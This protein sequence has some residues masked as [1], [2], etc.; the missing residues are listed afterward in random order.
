MFGE[1]ILRFRWVWLFFLTA[2]LTGAVFLLPGLEIRL[3]ADDY[4]PDKDPD[5]A[6]YNYMTSELGDEDDFLLLAVHRKEGI[7]DSVFLARFQAFTLDAARLPHITAAR[8]LAN[9]N[10]LKRTPFGVLSTPLLHIS[11][12]TLY[13]SDS[14]KILADERLLERLVSLDLKTLNVILELD[15]Q[16]SGKEAESLISSIEQLKREYAFPEVHLMGRKYFE[17]SHNRTSFRELVKGFF[18]C[19]GLIIVLLGYLYRSLWAVLL[20]LLVYICA[21]LLF[22]G[23]LVLR[24]HPVDVMT[25]L[26]PTILLIVSVSDVIHFFSKYEDQVKT[27]MN[28]KKALITTLNRIGLMLFL[29][30]FSTAIG[31]L[32]F[33]NSSLPT[34]RNFGGDIAVG[35]VLTFLITITLVP[36]ALLFVSEKAIH[37][38][39]D[40]HKWWNH[41]AEQI[42]QL[43]VQRPKFIA[44][45]A[46]LLILF[47][48]LVIPRINTNHFFAK[49][50]PAD[51]P[52]IQ[53][54]QFFEDHLG[55]VRTFEIALKPKA[56]KRLND[57]NVLKEIEKLHQHVDSLPR[58]GGVYS[59][60]TYY[61][62]L[63]KAWH[64]SRQSA[65]ALP[66]TQRLLNRQE[67]AF[68]K[69]SGAIFHQILNEERTIGKISARMNDPGLDNI[70]TLNKQVADWISTKLDSSLLET[71]IIGASAMAD[72]IQEYSIRSMFTGLAL[73]LA[74]IGL[75]IFLLYREVRTTLTVLAINLFPLILTGAIMAMSGIVLRCA[76]SV[77]FSIGFVI[78][79]DDTIH[80]VGRFR[81]ERSGGLTPV[82]SAGITLRE[83]GRAILLTSFV[84]F[85]GFIQLITSSF[86]DAQAIGILVSVMLV[87]AL[88][89]DLFLGPLLLLWKREVRD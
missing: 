17:V 80:F 40:W 29:T 50:L 59:P 2:A 22:L 83:T 70:H 48:L 16:L 42:L 23:Y 58:T 18:L 61:K 3:D 62:S 52:S 65:Y 84:L 51:H 27:G 57:L 24:G 12:P 82:E 64:S 81:L 36:F 49:T 47:S 46:V 63:N 34:L 32:T 26:A 20:P 86:R 60:A 38:R 76:T 67:K 33:L 45:T 78:A 66:P 10:D 30:S 9:L 7:F 11:N 53:S 13:S 8:S 31:F 85:F 41:K 72:K 79:I 69:Q 88:L 39:T 15:D 5:L 55:G 68:E 19:I 44:G 43:V 28:K 14:L 21:V 56:G 25:N 73:A 54:A 37:I 87:F 35:V 1:S 4:F 6:F 74:A 77:I 71:R 75:L 89:A